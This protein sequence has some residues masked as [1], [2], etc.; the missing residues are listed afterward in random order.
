MLTNMKKALLILVAVVALLAIPVAVLRADR[1]RIIPP[2]ELP[3]AAQAFIQQ[4]FP[5]QTITFAKKEFDNMRTK[6]E[7]NLDNGT[8]ITFDAKGVWDKVDCQYQAVPAA[9]IPAPIAAAVQ[10]QFPNMVITK[11]DKE[12]HGYDIELGDELELK[13]NKNGKLLYIDD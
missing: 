8:E 2:S 5:G 1:D 6:Y 4:H 7:A 3:A 13:F 10:Q 9:L 12:R 11:I